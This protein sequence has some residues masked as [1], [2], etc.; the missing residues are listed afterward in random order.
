M[1]FFTKYLELAKYSQACSLAYFCQLLGKCEPF[2]VA[3]RLEHSI[4]CV[5]SLQLEESV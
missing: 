3:A 1:K 4:V 2:N 5:M